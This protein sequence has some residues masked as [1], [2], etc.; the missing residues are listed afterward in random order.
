MSSA[1]E[2]PAAGPAGGAEQLALIR[3]SVRKAKEPRAKPRT[4]RGAA[5]AGELP[6]ARVLVD[7]GLL[8]LDQYFDYAVPAAMD[9]QARPGV[10]VRVRF[11]ARVVRGRREGGELH[12]GF[13]IERL[14]ASDYPGP[15]APLAQVLS[16]EPVLGPALLK[17]CRAVADRYAGALADVVQLAVPP[18]RAR[19]ESGPP[20]DVPPPP[21]RP[22]AG[23][24]RR[25]ATGPGYLDALAD[26]GSPR[27]VWT[28][29]PGPHWPDELAR[30]MAATLA[31]GRGALAVLPDGRAVARVDAALTALLGA[32]HHVVLTADSGPE[33]RYRRWL[34]VNRGH[35]KAVVGT[36]AAMFAPVQDLGLAALWD[37]GDSSH[38]EPHAPQPHARDVLL[39]RAAEEHCAFLLGG[40]SVTVEGAQLVDSRWA[41]PLA[42]PRERVRAAAPLIRTVGD[43]DQA[44]DAAARTAR[45]PSAAWQVTRD[46]LRHGP[47]LVQVPRRGYVPRLA[48]ERCREPARCAHCAGPLELAEGPEAGSSGTLHC[49]WCGRPEAG[50]HCGACGGVRLRAQVVG[51]RRTADELGRAFPAVPV[52]TSGRDGVLDQVS[53]RPALVVATP[54]A[55]PVA[56]GGYAAALLL[57]GWALL[58]RPDLRAGEEALRRWLTAAA[59]V[60]P[61]GEGGTVVVVAEPTLRPVQALVRWD[62]AGHAVREL[63]ERA[64]LGFP[65]VSRM[66]SVTGTPAAVA[67]LLADAQLPEG[68]DV[69]GPVPLPVP[70]PG[71]PRRPG[72]PPPGESWERVLLRVPPGTGAALAAALKTAQVARIARKRTDPVRVRVDPPDIG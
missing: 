3:E 25:Y 48:C 52:R 70:P 65:P 64:E 59:L 49:G 53:G 50:W 40:V 68:T 26:G 72:D 54:G 33:E 34:A 17:L 13:V 45:L 10:R 69:L 15:L 14:P 42:A 19:A 20:P 16:P 56:D 8:H 66:A 51:A 36:R 23:T 12:D 11:G 71:R 5:L 35:V 58:G 63:A 22:D 41:A 37:D 30:A 7:K 61:A 57:D 28:A 46:A 55:E 62:P 32:G 9:E 24:W 31:S 21:A 27:A 6:V 4:W 1:N 44:R 60:R 47:V 67:D 29:L 43:A 39:L 18:R 38:A 2:D